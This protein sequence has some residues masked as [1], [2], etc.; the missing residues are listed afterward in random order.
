MSFRPLVAL[1]IAISCLPS[2]GARGAPRF[3]E[4]SLTPVPEGARPRGDRASR[5]MI[6]SSPGPSA[7]G[8]ASIPPAAG[9]AYV[10]LNVEFEDVESCAR[11]AVAGAQV[12]A[13]HDRF[14]DV[15]IPW[16][17]E[18]I[19]DRLQLAPGL[20]CLERAG[21]VEVPP[22]PGITLVEPTRAAPQPAEKIVQGGFEGWTGRGVLIAIVDSGVDFRNPDFTTVDSTGKVVSRIAAMW[23]M[24][25]D[26][27]A[28]QGRGLPPPLVL[29]DGRPFGTVFDRA[30]LTDALRSKSREIPPTDMV[31]HGTAC[32]GIATGNGR[33]HPE[34]AML[35]GAAPGADLLVVRLC[36]GDCHQLAG[37]FTGAACAWADSI[38][39]R[40]GRPLVVSCSFGAQRGPH[41]GTT[42]VERQLDARFSEKT[43]GRALC[44]A[45]G[46]EGGEPF[47]TRLTLSNVPA[48]L[49]WSSAGEQV[50]IEVYLRSGS[51]EDL[52]VSRV[53]P[54]SAPRCT[55][56]SS[57]CGNQQPYL[58]LEA[59]GD[60]GAVA[61]ATRSGAAVEADVYILGGKWS[62]DRADP[63]RTIA[64]PGTCR[65][66]ITVG[67]YLWNEGFNQDG[68][69]VINLSEL[70]SD[71]P[72]SGVPRLGQPSC[73]SSR[74]P[75]RDGAIK[76]DVLAP[77]QAFISSIARTPDGKPAG[78]A[79][80][81]GIG[82]YE[83]LDASGHGR[84]FRGSS[85]ANAYVAGIVALMLEQD[86]GL[87]AGTIRKR[88]QESATE[89]AF[90][91]A[92]PNAVSGHGKLDMTA[93]RKLLARSPAPGSGR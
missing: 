78:L 19:R 73:F 1:C 12:F 6:Q 68:F 75:S 15:L 31:G 89:D 27:Y 59:E 71:C 50:Q 63:E 28:R 41:D 3:A 33:S 52:R 14:A 38:A 77:G 45:A 74:G 86:P 40:A 25:S 72:G 67:S 2:G 48:V 32:A 62:G 5:F 57:G 34:T 8:S 93:I 30:T 51:L 70:G 24:N 65:S 43:P 85:A 69:G 11:F 18:D 20:R 35:R 87:T 47:H 79:R 23:D 82:S 16:G 56:N 80:A 37:M 76:P 90:T 84:L 91:G 42:V 29:P 83:G 22:Q 46:N 13:R 53:L 10:G 4:I 88:L 36:T 58:V 66:A 60:S 21:T 61:L 64:L 7:P 17:A 39:S 44:V 26:L 55:E 9:H 54:W 81:P 49:D 92:V